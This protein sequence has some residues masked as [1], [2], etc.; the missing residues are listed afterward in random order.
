MSYTEHLLVSFAIVFHHTRIPTSVSFAKPFHP[1]P[2]SG[3][4]KALNNLFSDVGADVFF[5]VAVTA[6]HGRLLL[7]DRL[8]VGGLG[9][10][11]VFFQ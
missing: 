2:V 6:L 10:R 8:L 1:A 4:K 5:I 11:V 9:F 7:P 3:G